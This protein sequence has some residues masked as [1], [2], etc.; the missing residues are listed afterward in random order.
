MERDH[1]PGA[2]AAVNRS[3]S[4]ERAIGSARV[5]TAIITGILAGVVGAIG[6]FT[7]SI[8]IV[9]AAAIL[10]TGIAYVVQVRMRPAST[11]PRTGDAPLL[12]FLDRGDTVLAVAGRHRR[13]A[14]AICLRV[15]GLDE[16]ARAHG[17]AALQD[18]KD[19][20]EIR[21]RTALRT[22]DLVHPLTRDTYAVILS[23]VNGSGSLPLVVEKILEWIEVPFAIAG[24]AVEVQGTAGAAIHP[25]HGT[26]AT[27]LISCASK[28][29]HVARRA[30]MPWVLYAQG[31]EGIADDAVTLATGL[32]RAINSGEMVLHYQPQVDLRDGRVRSVEVLLRWEHP[33]RGTLYPPEFLTLVEHA[34]AI[35]GLAKFVLEGA[36]SQCARWLSEGMDLRVSVNLSGRNLLDP[37]LPDTVAELLERWE[38]DPARLEVEIPEADIPEDAEAS[39]LPVLGRL[40][41]LGV[42]V[43]ID[44]FGTGQANLAQLRQL[45]VDQIKIDRSFVLSMDADED[46]GTIVRSAIALARTLGIEVAAE[47]VETESVWEELI[48]LRCDAAQGYFV[49][50]PVPASKLFGSHPGPG[51]S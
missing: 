1:P 51:T 31:I 27:A 48:D 39:I 34:P 19:E 22:S 29:M 5:S 11:E 8:P 24:Q 46:L 9:V 21:I 16:V 23:E 38:L 37:Q 33:E 25:D 13:K 6:T 49:S 47:G 42:R 50:R 36:L 35:R 4:T 12:T 26:A 44:D 30:Q 7:H 20:L 2:A 17:D 15:H 3:D 10:T 40:H 43:T 41:E 18:L 45:P 32:G 28:A 14:G